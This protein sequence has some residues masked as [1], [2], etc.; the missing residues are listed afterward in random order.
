MI[1]R[2]PR[3]RTLLVAG[4]LPALLVLAFGAKVLVMRHHDSVGRDAFDRGD[5]ALAHRSFAANRSLNFFERWIA[6]FDEGTVHHAKGELDDA[7]DDYEI[8]LEVVPKR[9]E[10][11]VRINLA[12]AHESIG[13]ELAKQKDSDGATKEWQAGI[14]ALAGG[15]CPQQAGRGKKQTRDAKRVDERLRSKKQQQEQEQQPDEQSQQPPPAGDQ[16]D[17]QDPRQDQLE[18]NNQRGLEQ[19]QQD[20]D[21]YEGHD[22]SRPYSW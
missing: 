10:C 20:R 14:E 11:T 16:G 9:D 5:Y 22:Y 12:L 18:E 15:K 19:R 6:P 8:A 2:R 1:A 4:I 21:L 17:A 13:D 3:R 7:I